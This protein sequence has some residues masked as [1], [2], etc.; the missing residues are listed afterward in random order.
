MRFGMEENMFSLGDTEQI[1]LS[2]APPATVHCSS[3]VRPE[4]QVYQGQPQWRDECWERA[5]LQQARAAS[6]TLPRRETKTELGKADR[7]KS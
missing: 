6:A 7:C 4:C 5:E 3:L 2:L 1:T